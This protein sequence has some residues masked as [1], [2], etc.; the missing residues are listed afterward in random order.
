MDFHG[1]SQRE[2]TDFKT[3]LLSNFKVLP[4]TR[5]AGSLQNRQTTLYNE[6]GDGWLITGMAALL[7]KHIMLSIC[8]QNTI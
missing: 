1:A 6:R 5:D 4:Q 2:L 3:I 8:K 7:L